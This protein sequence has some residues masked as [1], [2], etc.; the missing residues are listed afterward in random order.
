MDELGQREQEEA[1][2]PGEQI[3]LSENLYVG[4]SD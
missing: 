1:P 4:H 3:R 2:Y